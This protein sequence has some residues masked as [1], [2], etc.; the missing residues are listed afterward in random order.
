[1]ADQL[2]LTATEAGEDTAISIAVSPHLWKMIGR[3]EPGARTELEQRLPVAVRHTFDGIVQLRQLT[4]D[5]LMVRLALA[6]RDVERY[7][8]EMDRR[9]G[10][11]DAPPSAS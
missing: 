8:T 11:H 6:R 2:V 7:E 5:E 4:A 3:L 1:M 9:A 10:G